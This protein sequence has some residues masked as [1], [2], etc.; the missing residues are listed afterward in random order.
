MNFIKKSINTVGNA[1]EINS[2]KSDRQQLIK[3]KDVYAKKIQ[4]YTLLEN[5]K[6][7]ILANISANEATISS[8]RQLFHALDIDTTNAE[9]FSRKHS[10]TPDI[11]SAF[12]AL[13]A[14]QMSLNQFNRTL[15]EIN[16]ETCVEKDVYQQ[17]IEEI[18]QEI[19]AVNAKLDKVREKQFGKK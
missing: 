4:K 17:K 19:H 16:K 12:D 11:L 3:K 10:D 7:S 13:N 1:V 6:A 9:E 2:L 8:I 5:L 18:D 15:D 14:S